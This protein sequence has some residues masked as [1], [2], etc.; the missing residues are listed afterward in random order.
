MSTNKE[1]D[2]A[3]T[4]SISDFL[5]PVDHAMLMRRIDAVTDLVYELSEEK[6]KKVGGDIDK[7]LVKCTARGA[8]ARRRIAAKDVAYR[9][10]LRQIEDLKKEQTEIA[11]KGFREGI[12]PSIHGVVHD[13]WEETITFE[14][15]HGPVELLLSDLIIVDDGQFVK[16]ADKTKAHIINKYAGTGF[17][18]R[19]MTKDF[20]G[21]VNVPIEWVAA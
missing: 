9:E 3:G 17:L 11:R 4:S 2:P 20:R 7:L 1:V 21:A 6:L 10:R 14:T 15:D 5:Q 8:E 16:N 13:D 19:L 18:K 12:R